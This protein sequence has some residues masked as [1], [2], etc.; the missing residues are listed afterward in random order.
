MPTYTPNMNLA[1]YSQDDK[2]S[3]AGYNSNFDAI[4]AKIS[5]L[6]NDYIVARGK[7]GAWRYEKWASGHIDMYASFDDVISPGD[8]S[9]LGDESDNHF[10]TGQHG[11]L[12]LPPNLLKAKDAEVVSC[13]S[14]PFFSD[15][16]Y[17]LQ[18]GQGFGGIMP[19]DTAKTGTWRYASW[20][21]RP[22]ATITAKIC[23]QIKG[24]W[25]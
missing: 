19:G 17:V 6:S 5:E 22:D 10:S 1:K 24:R 7:N 12:D 23:I 18:F 3:P 15:T 4:D 20:N 8:W 9:S 2:V 11:E 25:K 13:V 14:L 21:G 16:G